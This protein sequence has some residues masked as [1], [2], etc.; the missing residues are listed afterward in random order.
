MP[1]WICLLFGCL[2]FN[3][4]SVDLLKFLASEYNVVGNDESLIGP[5]GVGDVKIEIYIRVDQ[6][7]TAQRWTVHSNGA[8]W[9][10][11]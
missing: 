10:I 2:L 7:E 1:L 9:K 6:P 8:I 4:L 3:E 11:Y 5:D